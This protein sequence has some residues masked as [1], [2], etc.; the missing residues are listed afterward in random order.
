MKFL[1][2]L[3]TW[4]NT[5]TLNTA[6]FTWRN[7][8]KVGEDDQGNVFYQNREKT[9]RWVIYNGESEASRIAPEWHGWLHHTWDEPP[10]DKP[11]AHKPG[12]SRIRKT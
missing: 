12:K 8:V 11:L 6:F 3:L 10:T 7:G 1:L 4:W 9:K 5:S 2:R